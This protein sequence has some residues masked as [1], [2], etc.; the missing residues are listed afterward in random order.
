MTVLSHVARPDV[1]TEF[2]RLSLVRM[3]AATQMERDRAALAILALVADAGD[4][5]P[6]S[7]VPRQHRAVGFSAVSAALSPRRA[8]RR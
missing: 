6:R 3:D 2:V 1:Q 8:R 4:V 5:P 7:S